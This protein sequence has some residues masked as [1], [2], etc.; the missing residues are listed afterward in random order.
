MQRIGQAYGLTV[1]AEYRTATRSRSTRGPGR[2]RPIHAADLSAPTGGHAAQPLTGAEDFSWV[3]EEVPGALVFLGACRRHRP[4]TASFN[5][6]AGAVF[7]DAVLADGMTLYADF[8][9]RRLEAGA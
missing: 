5:H 4:A 2:V 1:D 8:A 3:L 9:L 6:S 7:D